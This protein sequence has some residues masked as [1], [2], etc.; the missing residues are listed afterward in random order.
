[1]TTTA[2]VVQGL[3]I[4]DRLSTL[5][6][7]SITSF[8]AHGHEYHLYT[9]QSVDNVPC[10]ARFED[11]RSVLPESMIFQYAKYPSYAG[12]ANYFRYK[13]LLERGGWWV[14]TDVVCL[15]PFEFAEDHVFASELAGDGT[16]TPSSGIIKA[17][18][19]SAAMGFAWQECR[20]KDTARL[21]WGETGSRLVAEAVRRCSLE[22][23]VVGCATFAPLPS[24]EWSRTL[25]PVQV[26]TFPEETRA[27]HFWNEMWRR[28]GREKDAH[29]PPGCLY[30]R[31][32]SRY[33]IQGPTA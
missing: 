27:I 14:D 24:Y 19:G 29:Y 20:R 13:L 10:G 3:W 1:M 21:T 6:R 12:F 23:F 22:R 11:A 9:Y 30:E 25:D 16:L 31:L 33:L 7:L 4:G 15:R 26:P 32:K 18:A 2:S 28:D 17:P 8:L 5:E